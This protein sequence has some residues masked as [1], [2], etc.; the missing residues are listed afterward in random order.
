MVGKAEYMRQRDDTFR[1][2]YPLGVSDVRFESMF[3]ET[4]METKYRLSWG[5]HGR[6]S[7]RTFRVPASYEGQ[8]G[9]PIDPLAYL[10]GTDAKDSEELARAKHLAEGLATQVRALAAALTQ[11]QALLEAHRIPIPGVTGVGNV[12]TPPTNQE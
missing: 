7:S 4:R 5:F 8:W 10:V 6:T 2:R 9:I 11:C 1:P 12:P 3:D